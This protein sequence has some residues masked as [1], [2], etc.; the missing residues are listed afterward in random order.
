MNRR[1]FLQ[2]A[3]AG[4]AAVTVTSRM[5]SAGE[6]LAA[7]ALAKPLPRQIVWQDCEVGAIFHF[8]LPLFA[9]GGWTQQNARRR[10]WDPA[11]YRPEQLDTDQWVAAAKAMGARYAIV[12]ATHFNGFLQWETDVYPYG[13]RQAPWRDGKADLVR[14]FT[15]S[16]RKAGLLPGVYLSCFRNAYH[17][18]DRYRV[19]YGK[20]GDGQAAFARTCEKM[21]EELCSRYGPLVQIWFD[22]GLIAPADGGPDVLPIVDR[23]QPEMVFYHSPERREHR[24][25]G[26]EAGHA[27]YPCWATMPGLEEAEAA[28]KGAGKGRKQL[29]AHGDPDGSLWS[30]GMVDVP[31]RNHFWFWRPGTDAKVA[32]LASVLKWYE[33]SVGRNANLMVGLTPD[34]R[35]LLPEAD[36]RRCEEFGRE[37]RRRFAA[38]LAETKGEGRGVVLTLARPAAV[39]YVSIMEEIAGGE[40]VRAYVVEGLA[41]DGTW[42]TLGEGTSVGHKRLQAVG[43]TEVAK[44]RLRVTEAA[45]PPRIRSL[46]VYDTAEA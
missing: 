34:T 15:D 29:L 33:Q 26:N 38:P 1:R 2:S 8:D 22:A 5:R 30:P 36:V 41:A 35:G 19:N 23:Y 13:L 4:A 45:A 11:L 7:P 42:R 16:C 40:R 44:V 20:G 25:I 27:G 32:P 28:H 3:A 21:V 17:K 24:W 18:V 31:L 39:D 14:D 10:T 9:E 37:I 43:R 12:T 6:D 46:A